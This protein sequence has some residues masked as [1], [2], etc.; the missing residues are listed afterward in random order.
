MTNYQKMFKILF[1]DDD[2]VIHR[3]IQV[4]LK[5]W[6]VVYTFSAE[7]ALNIME[8]ENIQIVISDINMPSMSGMELLSKIKK[9]YGTTQVII[10]TGEGEI[11]NLFSALSLGANDFLLK[12]IDKESLENAL[13]NTIDKIS[14]WKNAMKEIFNRKRN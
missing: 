14:R 13:K 7:D 9:R 12:P 2:P 1:V 11:D 4:F 5:D 3:L 8:N 10:L 6:D